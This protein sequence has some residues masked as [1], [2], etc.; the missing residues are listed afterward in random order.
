MI[1]VGDADGVG[2]EHAVAM[3]KLRGGGDQEAATTGTLTKVPAARLVDPSGHLS[4]W[5]VRRGQDSRTDGDPVP[6]RYAAGQSVTLVTDE[7]VTGRARGSRHGRPG[8]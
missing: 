7:T 5:H 6:G 1:I 4:H 8:S 2:P 3:F